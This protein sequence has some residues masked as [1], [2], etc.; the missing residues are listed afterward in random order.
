M[1]EINHKIIKKNYRK[2]PTYYREN[3]KNEKSRG[4]NKENN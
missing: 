1:C 4:G 2:I 3:E